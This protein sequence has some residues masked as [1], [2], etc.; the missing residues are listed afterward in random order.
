MKKNSD[1]LRWGGI[2]LTHIV[3]VYLVYYVQLTSVHCLK[4]TMQNFTH[5]DSICFL[6]VS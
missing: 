4:L 3:L 5:L 6:H 1:N 2:F